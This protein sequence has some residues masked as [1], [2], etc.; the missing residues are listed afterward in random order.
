[1]TE[2]DRALQLY[3][4]CSDPP[5]DTQRRTVGEQRAQVRMHDSSGFLDRRLMLE[6]AGT[7]AWC[8]PRHTKCSKPCFLSEM[9]SY[10]V[11]SNGQAHTA[12]LLVIGT[13]YF[14][15]SYI[16]LNGIL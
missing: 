5:S 8:P 4:L 7:S 14:G 9:A 12:R 15:P 2:L 1:M 16:E 10:D 11:A 3:R 13:H 6:L